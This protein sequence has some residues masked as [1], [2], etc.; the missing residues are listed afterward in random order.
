MSLS[1][2]CR[3]PSKAPLACRR[4]SSR[5][6]KQATTVKSWGGSRSPPARLESRL[7]TAEALA[8]P[9]R[10]HRRADDLRG[11]VHAR[12]TVGAVARVCVSGPHAPIA[13]RLARSAERNGSGHRHCAGWAHRGVVSHHTRSRGDLLRNGVYLEWSA[14]GEPRYQLLVPLGRVRA[15]ANGSVVARPRPIT[16]NPGALGVAM[17]GTIGW[18]EV[19]D[20]DWRFHNDEHA[21]L[22]MIGTRAL[23]AAQQTDRGFF[24]FFWPRQP[25]GVLPGL[26]ATG[27]GLNANCLSFR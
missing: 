11:R 14:D 27:R 18:R 3:R 13:N 19:D 2:A 6:L 7:R 15:P 25:E 8:D 17:A 12:V 4:N 10:R 22:P 5:H 20:G 23:L 24:Y 16:G 26:E 1:S 21:Y 9:H